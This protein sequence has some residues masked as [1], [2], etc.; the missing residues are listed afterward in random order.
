MLQGAVALSTT[1]AEYIAVTD[2]VKETL[3]LQGLVGDLGSVHEYV[4]VHCD[5]QSA[6]HLPKNQVHHGRTKHIDV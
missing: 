6:I 5:S 4:E 2:A 1:K 3:W